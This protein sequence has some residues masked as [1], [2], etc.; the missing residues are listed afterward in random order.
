MICDCRGLVQWNFDMHKNKIRSDV[1]IIIPKYHLFMKNDIRSCCQ[2]C[3]SERNNSPQLQGILAM[4]VRKQLQQ[5][6]K[7]LRDLSSKVT[8]FLF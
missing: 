3:I 2:E 4:L 7:Q 5:S 1:H 8:F 6:F